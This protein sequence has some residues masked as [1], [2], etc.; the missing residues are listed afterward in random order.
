[1]SPNPRMLLLLLLLTET[2]VEA[3]HLRVGRRLWKLGLGGQQLGLINE[4]VVEVRAVE[5]V[6]QHCLP[7]LV[8]AQRGSAQASVQRSTQEE[9]QHR[10]RGGYE[11]ARSC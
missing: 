4:V 5:R 7:V 1:M 8:A 10:G 9:R 11:L 2:V 3:G 6:Q